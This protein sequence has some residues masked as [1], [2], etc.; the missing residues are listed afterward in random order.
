MISAL[1][2]LGGLARGSGDF[3]RAHALLEERLG[4]SRK[5]DALQTVAAEGVFGGEDE[6]GP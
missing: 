2:H 3:G 4:L 6:P 5:V 1:R